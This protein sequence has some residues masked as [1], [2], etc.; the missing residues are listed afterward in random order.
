MSCNQ[1]NCTEK[2]MYRYTWPGRDEAGIC[3][4]HVGWLRN[5]A[6]ALGMHLQT[7]QLEPEAAK[8]KEE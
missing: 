8:T 3:E 5:V 6:E 7:I 2:A 4:Q 1:K